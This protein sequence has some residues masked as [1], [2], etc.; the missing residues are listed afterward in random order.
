MAAWDRF[1]LRW[2]FPYEKPTSTQ[3][4]GCRIT[5]LPLACFKITGIPLEADTKL[6]AIQL[7]D[8]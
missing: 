1:C 4:A 5:V 8:I 7:V 2:A 6:I 3:Q